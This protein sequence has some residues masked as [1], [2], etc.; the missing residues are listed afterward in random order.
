M[1]GLQVSFGSGTQ[2][3]FGE[4]LRLFIRIFLLRELQES[5][6]EQE[7]VHRIG[8]AGRLHVLSAT[9]VAPAEE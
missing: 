6:L 9:R 1:G 5:A 2:R 3:Q 7:R 8:G 4:V